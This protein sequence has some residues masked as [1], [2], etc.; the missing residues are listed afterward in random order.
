MDEAV[1]DGAEH[2]SRQ[3]G[4]QQPPDAP[5]PLPAGPQKENAEDERR[6]E[7]AQQVEDHHPQRGA[8][9]FIPMAC[10]GNMF[11]VSTTRFQR[12]PKSSRRMYLPIL[13]SMPPRVVGTPVRWAML[14]RRPAAPSKRRQLKESPYLPLKPNMVTRF[15]RSIWRGAGWFPAEL[16]CASPPSTNRKIYLRTESSTSI[17]CN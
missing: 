15:N 8:S 4:K 14:E 10:H 5:S 1:A 16:G 2:A 7:R 13:R 9:H 12:L 3:Q 6:K 11:V 17:S